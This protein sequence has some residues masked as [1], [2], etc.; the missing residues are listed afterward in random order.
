MN[1]PKISVVIPLYNK[2]NHIKDCIN[3]VLAQS[4]K[5]AEIVIVDDGSTDNSMDVVKTENFD[6]DVNIRVISQVNKGVSAARNN[7]V[8]NAKHD[9]IAFLDADDIWLPLFLEEMINLIQRY[10]AVGFYTSKYQCVATDEQYYDAKIDMALVEAN[11]FNP[12]GMLINNFFEI[13][14]HGDLPFMVSS[15]VISR[16]LFEQVG[17]FPVGEAIG[18]DQDLFAKVALQGAIAYSPN[19][20]LLYSI[21]A[22]NKATHYNVPSQECAFSKRLNKTKVLEKNSMAKAILKYCAAHLCHLAKL[23]IKMGRT[24]EAKLLLSDPRC[25]LK[26]KHRI[27]LYLWASIVQGVSRVKQF[28]SPSVPVSK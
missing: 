7:G 28:V 23:N 27:Y 9:Y 16:S 4:F 25:Q 12:N 26:P 22:D 18:E 19:I 24:D 6:S 10:P 20:N 11:G 8:V 15:S 14:S 17:G 13:A 1:N 3:S 5:A 21:D 2:Q